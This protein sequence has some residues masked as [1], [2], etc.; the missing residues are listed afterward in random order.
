[1]A[2]IDPLKLMRN[3]ATLDAYRR[4]KRDQRAA[5]QP[6]LAIGLALVPVQIALALY[7]LYHP[8]HRELYLIFALLMVASGLSTSIAALK[9]RAF[10]QSHPFVTPETASAFGGES[11][12]ASHP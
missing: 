1:M 11:K 8:E 5:G 2:E 6:W 10:R 7:G 3:T 4:H 9:S 12:V